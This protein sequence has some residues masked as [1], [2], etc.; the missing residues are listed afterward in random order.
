MTD[1]A[2]HFN[3]QDKLEHAC[4]V[5]RKLLRQD[6]RLVIQASAPVLETLDAMLWNMSAHDFVA[7]CQIGDAAECVDASPILLTQDAQLASHHDVLL[8]LEDEVP[9]GFGRFAR[10]IEVV[11]ATDETDRTA[12]RRRWKHYLQ[13]GYT[14]ERHDLVA[15]SA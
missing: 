12:A 2:F 7:H 11:S 3:A 4:R 8:N 13:R 15:R 14:L 1:I 9:D 6:R 5:A 10:L